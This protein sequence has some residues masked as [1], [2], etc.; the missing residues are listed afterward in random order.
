MKNRLFLFTN[1]QTKYC[2]NK[3]DE[4]TRQSIAS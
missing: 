4:N 3:K 2:W 1:M